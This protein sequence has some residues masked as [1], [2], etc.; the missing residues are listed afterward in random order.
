VCFSVR[1][2]PLVCASVG[3]CLWTFQSVQACECS[4]GYL[5]IKLRVCVHVL[6]VQLPASWRRERSQ[7]LADCPPRWPW[8]AQNRPSALRAA[9]PAWPAD[10]A[11]P[12]VPLLGRCRRRCRR[13]SQRCCRHSLR[14]QGSHEDAAAVA[15]RG[16]LRTSLRMQTVLPFSPMAC[17]QAPKL[18][19][20]L[21]RAGTSCTRLCEVLGVLEVLTDTVR[22]SP[23]LRRYGES[24]G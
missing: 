9:C 14:T 6:H 22:V 19:A 16:G 20:T 21:S 7:V 24:R 8:P 18:P 12:R 11:Y 5:S 10:S 3:V 17:R 2:V 1:S 13:R 15:A 23:A 4:S